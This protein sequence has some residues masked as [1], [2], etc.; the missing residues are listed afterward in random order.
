MFVVVFNLLFII[1]AILVCLDVKFLEY[2]ISVIGSILGLA[3]VTVC[4]N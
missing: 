4:C 3:G 1:G 2:A